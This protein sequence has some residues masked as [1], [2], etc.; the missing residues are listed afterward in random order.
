MWIRIR[1]YTYTYVSTTV[2]GIFKDVEMQIASYIVC[3]DYYTLPIT[4]YIR[5]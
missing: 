5:N 2:Y 1:T 4:S 3:T